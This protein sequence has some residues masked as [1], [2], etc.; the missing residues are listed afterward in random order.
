MTHKKQWCASPG[1]HNIYSSF[2]G[3]GI[4]LYQFDITQRPGLSIT[5]SQAMN[6]VKL[7]LSLNNSKCKGKQLTPGVNAYD[8]QHRPS[9]Y[10]TGG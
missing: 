3:H 1:P 4:P 6:H 10:H 5:L 7:S 2:N 8:N 9:I